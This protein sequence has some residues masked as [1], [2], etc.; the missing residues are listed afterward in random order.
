MTIIIHI[1]TYLQHTR[2]KISF[3]AHGEER[4]RKGQVGVGNAM[5]VSVCAFDFDLRAGRGG[6][7]LALG[8]LDGVFAFLQLG[9]EDLRLGAVQ[10][11]EPHLVVVDGGDDSAAG[12]EGEKKGMREKKRAE[13][14]KPYPINDNIHGSRSV[15]SK[16][17]DKTKKIIEVG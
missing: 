1:R 11:L 4:V 7:S 16:Q 15:Q 2:Q 8:V 13:R 6:V 9:D 5:C 12:R 10:P 14:S 17:L 3:L